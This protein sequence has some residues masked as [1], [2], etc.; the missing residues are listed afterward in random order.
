MPSQDFN[1]A[2]T[3]KTFTADTAITANMCVIFGTLEDHVTLA[4]GAN[5]PGFVGFALEDAASGA[6]VRVHISGGVAKAIAGATFAIGDYLMIE[7]ADG[8]LKKLTLGASNQYVVAKALRAGADGDFVPVKIMEF[9][10][11]GA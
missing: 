10:A 8:R 4:S 1:T 6:Q 5:D 11:Q 9:V 2:A 3:V 7:G